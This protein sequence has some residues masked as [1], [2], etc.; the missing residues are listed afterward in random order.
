M[1][2]RPIIFIHFPLIIL[3]LTSCVES[4]NNKPNVIFVFADQWR[5][6][7]IGYNGNTIV[8]TPTI[9]KLSDESMIFSNAVSGCP[10]C[11]PYRASLI[12]GQ[13]PLTHGVIYNDK[14]LICT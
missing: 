11:C 12:T 1:K 8:K 5:A 3:L 7:D 9:D 10:V 13:Y 6:Q 14:P 4:Q 2:L